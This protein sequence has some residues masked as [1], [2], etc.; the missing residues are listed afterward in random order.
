MP[1]KMKQLFDLGNRYAAKSDWRD[2]ALTKVC[3]F[4]LGVI[5]GSCINPRNKKFA[6]IMALGAFGATY[7]I[8]MKKVYDIAKEKMGKKME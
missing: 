8:L 1:Q 7:I 4:S 6:R 5:T 3:L 2:F